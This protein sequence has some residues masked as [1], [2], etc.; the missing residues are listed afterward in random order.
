MV[1]ERELHEALREDF[2]LEFRVRD[3]AISV[4][5]LNHK[6]KPPLTEVAVK[7]MPQC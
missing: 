7:F 6:L 5:K 1:F 2:G 3:F 4:L